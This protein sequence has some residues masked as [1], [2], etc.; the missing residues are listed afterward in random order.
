[1]KERQGIKNVLKCIWRVYVVI[2]IFV[3]IYLVD[4][5]ICKDILEV[6][7]RIALKEQ[8]TV[9]VNGQQYDNVILDEMKF[10]HVKKGDKVILER[11]L[12]A[13]WEYREA[14]LCINNIH[15]TLSMYI[16]DVLEYEYGHERVRQNKA[17]G[18]GYLF[19]NFYDEY[20]GKRL[21]LEYVATEDN[22]FSQIS[23]MWIA[24]WGN[25]YRYIMTQNRLP[26]LAGGFFMVF[27]VMMTLVLAFKVTVISKY[28]GILWLAIFS[29]CIGVWSMCYYNVM[30]IFAIPLYY[31]SIMEH[32]SLFMTP[33]PIMAYMQAFVK[34]LNS[35]IVSWVYY[36]L[37]VGQVV[38]TSV[39]IVL[40]MLG[41]VHTIQ[42]LPIIQNMFVFHLAFVF[43]IMVK[44]IQ[45]NPKERKIIGISL[46]LMTI[47]VMYELVGY[48]FVRYDGYRIAEVKGVSSIG[49]VVF[50]SGLVLDLYQRITQSMMEEQE[51]ALLIKR[52]YTDELTQLHNR[53]YCSEFMQ[54]IDDIRSRKY[55]V[56]SFDLNGLK[57]ANDTYGHTKGDELIC[58]AALVLKQAFSQDGVVGRM[59]GDEFIAVIEND[60]KEKIEQLIE[61]FHVCINVVNEQNPGLDLSISY[62]YATCS[63]VGGES[64][65]KVYQLADN[66]M[67][68]YKRK[69]KSAKAE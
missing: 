34:E 13:E 17:T 22:A 68:E 5:M 46:I 30:I 1:M 41:I 54:K 10:E 43:F 27:G 9:V 67:Y 61:N 2:S 6:S 33:I 53:T 55:T 21:R 11:M 37:L 50:L 63:E 24:E 16:D 65:E 18:S 20:K 66:R 49:F 56:M 7:E 3:V 35:K 8:W 40:H 19:V 31:I 52:A 44:R 32:I 38:L 4:H 26:L 69:V 47:C 64:I 62:G 28:A 60:D 29:I 23:E 25:S 39:A 15:T 14:V 42:T 58:Q 48:S 36:I 45:K 57:Q 12:P 59:G 51:K